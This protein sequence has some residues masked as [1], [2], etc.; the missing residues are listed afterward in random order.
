MPDGDKALPEKKA[1]GGKKIPEK[2]DG[3]IKHDEKINPAPDAAWKR[4]NQGK[5]WLKQELDD[6][7]SQHPHGV[8]NDHKPKGP[9]HEK[10]KVDASTPLGDMRPGKGVAD[11]PKEKAKIKAGGSK[12]T[13]HHGQ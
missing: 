10:M 7:K 8:A 1:D 5:K 11:P 12:A 13:M 6:L 3:G 2:K 4:H 9:P